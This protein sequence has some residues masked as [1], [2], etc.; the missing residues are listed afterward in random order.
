MSEREPRGN[1]G[2]KLVVTGLVLLVISLVM[3]LAG[4]D[5]TWHTYD[6]D[7]G[8]SLFVGIAAL[9]CLGVGLANLRGRRRG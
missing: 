7:G 4:W 5:V 3:W 1:A 9:L 8:V 2:K 6:H